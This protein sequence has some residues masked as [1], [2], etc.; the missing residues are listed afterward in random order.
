MILV[1]CGLSVSACRGDDV[2]T[3][4]T[5]HTMHTGPASA[6]MRD[7]AGRS[8]GTLTLT[9]GSEGIAVSGRLTGLAPG[10]HAIHVHTTGRCDPPFESAGGH[11][12]P[13]NRQHGAQNPQGPHVGDL[14]NVTV[15][16]DGGVTVEVTTPGGTLHGTS[17]LMDADGAAV[18]IHAQPDDYRS[19]PA[20][21]AG[22]RIACG[23]VS[24]S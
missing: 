15:A 9:E 3:A 2:R 8:V 11:W 19:D 1:G 22:G 12:N 21:N 16:S 5:A 4:D 18:V 6:A 7:S 10:D 13:T 23:V 20:G 17:G 24:G 14:P